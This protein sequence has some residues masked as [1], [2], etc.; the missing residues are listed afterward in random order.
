MPL[1]LRAMSVITVKYSLST[2]AMSS[3]SSSSAMSEKLTM[4]EKKIV[5]LVRWWPSETLSSPE[6]IPSASSVGT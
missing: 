1:C 4:S 5:S 3:G 2:I 6:R